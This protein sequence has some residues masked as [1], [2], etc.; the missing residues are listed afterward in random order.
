MHDESGPVG[1]LGGSFD[2]VHIGHLRGAMAVREALNLLRVDLVPAAQSPLKPEAMLTGAHRLAMLEDLLPELGVVGGVSLQHCPD[3][4][5]GAIVG[6][7]A[8]RLLPQQRQQAVVEQRG[9]DGVL[10]QYRRPSRT[11]LG[12]RRTGRQRPVR[13]GSHSGV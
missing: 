1:F 2:P 9:R 13:K 5:R 6:E 3:H 4:G 8:A 12:E 7:K 11:G 10:V